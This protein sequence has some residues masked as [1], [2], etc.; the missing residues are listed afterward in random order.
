MAVEKEV[1]SRRELNPELGV[2]SHCMFLQLLAKHSNNQWLFNRNVKINE[3]ILRFQD[4]NRTK[5]VRMH[6]PK[7]APSRAG[8]KAD[9]IDFLNTFHYLLALPG[10]C[11]F[12]RVHFVTCTSG[13][14]MAQANIFCNNVN[15]KILVRRME[16]ALLLQ[17]V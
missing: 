10:S 16:K 4:E 3:A 1:A 6:L 13:K 17:W 7:L 11:Y 9:N 12:N 14:N 8:R 5:K 2:R 15:W